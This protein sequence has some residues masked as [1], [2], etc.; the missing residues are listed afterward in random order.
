MSK[1]LTP[2]GSILTKSITSKN[3]KNYKLFNITPLVELSSKTHRHLSKA[4][5]RARQMGKYFSKII[6][7]SHNF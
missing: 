2:S 1:M 3:E 6:F 4:I 5:R 7:F